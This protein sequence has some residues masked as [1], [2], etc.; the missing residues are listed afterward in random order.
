M[1]DERGV[2]ADYC[3]PEHSAEPS[4]ALDSEVDGLRSTEVHGRV[5]VQQFEVQA[6]ASDF[7][8]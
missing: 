7:L 5:W 8:T 2:V 1:E 3:R 4:A 6:L